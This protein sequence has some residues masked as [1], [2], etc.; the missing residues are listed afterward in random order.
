MTRWENTLD[1]ECH[2]IACE[3]NVGDCQHIT[4]DG[5]TLPVSRFPAPRQAAA[6]ICGC[7]LGVISDI[8]EGHYE[9]ESISTVSV[10]L[11]GSF[12]ASKVK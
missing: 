11:L 6:L 7:F 8:Y 1:F 5:N 12:L 2:A 9:N 10:R 3:C 4:D